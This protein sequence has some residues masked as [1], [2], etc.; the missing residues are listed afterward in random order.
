MTNPMTSTFTTQ[1][2][3]SIASFFNLAT[4]TVAAFLA[5]LTVAVTF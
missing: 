3:D 4:I 5:L 1:A 2:D